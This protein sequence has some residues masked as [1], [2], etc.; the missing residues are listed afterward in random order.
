METFHVWQLKGQCL[1]SQH[2]RSRADFRGY[3]W[4]KVYHMDS[5]LVKL[6]R[7]YRRRRRRR[8]PDWRKRLPTHS[9]AT[10]MIRGYTNAV[11]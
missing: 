11:T 10:V 1:R 7:L 9:M 3:D 5:W 6:V 4:W 2:F 8:A